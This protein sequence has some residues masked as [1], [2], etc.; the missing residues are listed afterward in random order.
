MARPD[1]DERFRRS[2]LHRF[3][4]ADEHVIVAQRQ[5]WASFWKPIVVGAGGLVVLVVLARWLPA[6]ADGLNPFLLLGWFVG[7]G[8]WTLWRCLM[9]RRNGLVATDTRGR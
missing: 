2:K 9:W 4:L 6:S 3:L 5:H 7:I 1:L 8:G